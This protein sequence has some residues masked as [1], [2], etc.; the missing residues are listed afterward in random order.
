ML[1]CKGEIFPQNS[2]PDTP[3]KLQRHRINMYIE[4]ERPFSAIPEALDLLTRA[5]ELYE[6]LA[7]QLSMDFSDQLEEFRHNDFIDTSALNFR[8][9]TAS[10]LSF[11]RKNGMII[12]ARDEIRLKLCIALPQPLPPHQLLFSLQAELG[13]V[14]AGTILQDM[15]NTLLPGEGAMHA[16][17][18]YDDD[19]FEEEEQG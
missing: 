7:V 4:I 3:T 18:L 6:A 12:A 13:C 8:T 15:R 2:K 1:S 11:M 5:P 14:A 16:G 17:V 19:D 10:H 9:K